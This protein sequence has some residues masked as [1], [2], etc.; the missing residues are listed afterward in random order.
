MT[1]LWEAN[2]YDIVAAF[3]IP[4]RN[5]YADLMVVG[6]RPDSGDAMTAW[7]RMPGDREWVHGEHFPMRPS[8][9]RPATQDRAM[10]D[11]LVRAGWHKSLSEQL[12]CP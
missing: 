6:V 8:D 2:G 5:G 10:R 12:D 9:D 4:G 7:M 11:A 3:P 1:K